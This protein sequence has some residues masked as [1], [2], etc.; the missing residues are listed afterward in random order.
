M[1]KKPN[2]NRGRE[3]LFEKM[4]R[5]M[6]LFLAILVI[7]I[8]QA[9]ASVY[10]Q[11]ARLSLRME[12]ATIAEVFDAVEKQSDFFFF[13]NKGQID[14][15][16]KVS[17]DLENSKIDDVL[18]TVFGKNAVSYEIIGKNIIVKSSDL[19]NPSDAQQ[20]GKKISGK[21]TDQ[22]GAPLPGVTV[23]IKGTTIGITTDTDGNF[24][25]STPANAQTLAFSFIGMQG[26]EVEIQ[27]RSTLNI[28]LKQETIGLEEVVAIGYGTT[29]KQDLSAAVA[30]IQNMDRLKETPVLTVAGMIQGLVPGVTVVNQ[31]GQPGAGPQVTIRGTG[32][33]SESVLYV[34]D[35]VPD[36][37]FNPSDVESVTVLK[38]AAS[39]AIYGAHA[40]AAGVILITTRQSKMGKPSVEYSGFYGVKSAWKLPHALNASD[41][42]K[43]SN[44]A[45]TNAGSTPL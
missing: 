24:T 10:S 30:V 21:V 31:G 4:S 3:L 41:E 27:G 5:I 11:T 34:V 6:K 1:K 33:K 17:V 40:G 14:D 38:D 42:A 25:L 16:R 39:A 45:Y 26:Q 32:S 43:V 28:S 19:T 8:T 9:T 7:T 13:Y 44:L 37:P 2:L 23:V 12:N 15:Q 35:G 20:D 36:A 18:A 22:S 29:K